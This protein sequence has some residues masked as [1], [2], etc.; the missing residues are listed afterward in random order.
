[1]RRRIE[2][3]VV[4]VFGL[5]LAG[6]SSQQ[7]ASVMVA[8]TS[9]AAIPEGIDSVEVSVKRGG[10]ERF[11]NAY[12]RENSDGR[13]L[14]GTLA[15]DRPGDDVGDSPVTVSVI[16]KKGAEERVVRTATFS[17]VDGEQRLLRMPLR[18]ACYGTSTSECATGETCRAGI[19]E[20]D[21]VDL[22][23]A[24]A[25]TPALVFPTDAPTCHDASRCDGAERVWL[26]GTKLREALDADCTLPAVFPDGT[27]RSDLNMEFVWRDDPRNLGTPAALTAVTLDYDAAEGWNFTDESSARVKLVPGVCAAV[28][29]GRVLGTFETFGCAPKQ[30]LV[31]ACEGKNLVASPV[32]SSSAQ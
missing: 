17:F 11:F 13:L 21:A 18:L 8:V 32:S 19:C 5:V 1:M 25:Y 22:N 4:G 7:P 9:E 20:P 31:P 16:A 26:D 10:I 12:S 14:P 24:P 29:D 30:P 2:F 23:Q 27:P 3:G 28:R 6:C 15:V